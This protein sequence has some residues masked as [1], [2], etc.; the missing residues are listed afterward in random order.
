MA[1]IWGSKEYLRTIEGRK[2]RTGKAVKG[3]FKKNI[4]GGKG[5]V[6]ENVLGGRSFRNHL[7]GVIFFSFFFLL[8]IIVLLLLWRYGN[9]RFYVHYY[10]IFGSLVDTAHSSRY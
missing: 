1:I 9:I 7:T 8:I 4:G 10:H 3:N 2:K 6:L 5:R